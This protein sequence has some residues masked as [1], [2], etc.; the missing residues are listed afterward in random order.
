LI[1]IVFLQR[2]SLNHKLRFWVLQNF[3]CYNFAY[4]KHTKAP[5]IGYRTKWPTGWTSEWF[6]VKADEKKGEAYDYGD[7]SPETE[8]R[9]DM[10]I[11]QYETQFPLPVSQSGV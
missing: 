6:Y 8:L 5:V 11:V 10:T 9:H 2:I 4:R 1:I 3:G 7:E